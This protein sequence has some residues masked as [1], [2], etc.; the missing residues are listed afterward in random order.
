MGQPGGDPASPEVEDPDDP[1]F[2]RS[3]APRRQ[4]G[5]QNLVGDD[6]PKKGPR[7]PAVPQV[8]GGPTALR[9]KPKARPVIP[10]TIRSRD[11][12]IHLE[13]AVDGVVLPTGQR[14]PAGSR[15]QVLKAVQDLMARRQAQLRPGEPPWRPQI[16]FQV[17]PDGLRT[18]YQAFPALEPLGLVMTRENL[19]P[20]EK[21]GRP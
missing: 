11:W 13:C 5:D 18:Y 14:V 6:D 1:E 20:P 19:D 4:A 12:I 2:D 3:A 7:G 10:A 8:P 16:R 9:D 21:E 17:R 15:D